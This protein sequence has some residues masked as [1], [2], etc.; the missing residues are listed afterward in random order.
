MNQASALVVVRTFTN[1]ADAHVARSALDAAGIPTHLADDY[2]IALDW[3][4]SNAVGG[5]KLLV[6]SDRLDEASA[7]L[8]TPPIAAPS[9][10]DTFGEPQENLPADSCARCGGKDFEPLTRGRRWAAL[11]WLVVGAPL[12]PV[13][14]ALRC[15]QCGTT[16][17]AHE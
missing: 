2:V 12:V 1:V 8:E 4:Y 9:F 7:V 3:L 13:H 11:T 15:R 6:P 16:L 10:H 17:E 5:V 14:R